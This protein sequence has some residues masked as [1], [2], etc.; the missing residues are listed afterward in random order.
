MISP[1]GIALKPGRLPSK[2]IPE[3]NTFPFF[4]VGNIRFSERGSSA[5]VISRFRYPSSAAL[6]AGAV[7]VA[8]VSQG[9]MVTEA[10]DG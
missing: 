10:G 7:T 3:P 8:T 2:R 4:S 6:A 1:V 5:A 9:F